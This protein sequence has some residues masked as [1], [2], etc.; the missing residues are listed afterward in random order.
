MDLSNR[1]GASLDPNWKG[2]VVLFNVDKTPK[3]ITVPACG[4]R[5]LELHPVQRASAADPIVKQA[6]FDADTFTVP[7]RT[8][9]VFV[10]PAVG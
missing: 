7:A 9:A 2:V 6:G 8:T 10:E 4:G 1:E 3:T 5:L